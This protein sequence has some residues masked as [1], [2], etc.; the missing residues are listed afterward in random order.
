[1]RAAAPST[2]AAAYAH[3]VR[4]TGAARDR[5][6][7]RRSPSACQGVD[8][9]LLLAPRLA[10]SRGGP[11]A[12][13]SPGPSSDIAIATAVP[14]SRLPIS[15]AAA[16]AGSPSAVRAELIPTALESVCLLLGGWHC[17][18]ATLRFV[19]I[20]MTWRLAAPEAKAI[21]GKRVVSRLSN[22]AASV[23][24][25]LSA[26]DAPTPNV[27]T[28]SRRERHRR[29]ARSRCSRLLQLRGCR[30]LVHRPFVAQIPSTERAGAASAAANLCIG[31]RARAIACALNGASRCG[32]KTHIRVRVSMGDRH[33]F[34]TACVR[35][36]RS[37][38]ALASTS[39]LLRTTSGH[40]A[41]RQDHDCLAINSGSGL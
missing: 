16:L 20:A 31:R 12:S 10:V 25:Q 5:D 36:Q 2:A 24:E 38:R 13:G 27:V 40:V 9:R 35:E 7:T 32:A 37:T 28:A 26:T 39:W 1:M 3:A 8:R 15:V 6:S 29:C 18:R 4:I 41:W 11:R 23:R 17:V 14:G 34:V 22:I 21:A 30:C 33:G 19:A